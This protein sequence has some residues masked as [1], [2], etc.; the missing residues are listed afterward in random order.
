MRNVNVRFK[1]KRIKVLFIM[2]EQNPYSKWAKS[3]EACIPL[4]LKTAMHF[5]Q[6]LPA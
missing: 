4:Q 1:M 2:H 3:H 6:K 5:T